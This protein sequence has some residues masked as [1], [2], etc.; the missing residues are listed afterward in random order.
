M[1]LINEVIE[2]LYVIGNR[3][4]AIIL[5]MEN[6]NNDPDVAHAAH[7]VHQRTQICVDLEM[8]LRE[9]GDSNKTLLGNA[10]EFL[11]TE[12]GELNEFSKQLT[13]HGYDSVGVRAKEE[14]MNCADLARRLNLNQVN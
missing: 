7:L 11:R 6:L 1:T 13:E 10:I 14:A 2:K 8:D 9:N 12:V 5:E 3:Y 4:M